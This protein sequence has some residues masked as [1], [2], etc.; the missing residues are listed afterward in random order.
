MKAKE[1]INA[2]NAQSPDNDTDIDILLLGREID[3][4]NILE[5]VRNVDCS[6][7][8]AIGINVERSGQLNTPSCLSWIERLELT[9]AMMGRG[10]S[11]EI[12]D[13]ILIDFQKRMER[14]K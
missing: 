13:Q 6:G 8:N 9:K 11:P 4:L 7:I 3:F 12:A 5:V 1:L 10:V 2:I 14:F